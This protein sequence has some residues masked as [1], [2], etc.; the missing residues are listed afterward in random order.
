MNKLRQYSETKRIWKCT[1]TW[2]IVSELINSSNTSDIIN[3]LY[4]MEYMTKAAQNENTVALTFV[5]ENIINRFVAQLLKLIYP[6]SESRISKDAF[7]LLKTIIRENDLSKYSLEA[8]RIAMKQIENDNEYQNYIQI[9]I[10]HFEN[11]SKQDKKS[12][13]NFMYSLT[14][15]EDK[16]HDIFTVLFV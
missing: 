9:Y 10:W 13:C 6:N 1:S 11:S 4:M 5:I 2:D 8:L 12:L 14:L 7:P 15:N 3:G 16:T